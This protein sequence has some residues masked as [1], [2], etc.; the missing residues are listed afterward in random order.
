MAE[1]LSVARKSLLDHRLLELRREQ[2][3]IKVRLF[4]TDHSPA[5]LR[6][7]MELANTSAAG[8]QCACFG[9]VLAGRHPDP[10]THGDHSP[11]AVACAFEPWFSRVLHEHGFHTLCGLPPAPVWVHGNVVGDRFGSAG[12][13]LESDF[14]AAVDGRAP[15]DFFRNYTQVLDADYHFVQFRGLG[16]VPTWLYASRLWTATSVRD[17]ELQKL[18]SLLLFLGKLGED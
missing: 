12:Q 3:A 11:L 6:D 1:H 7:A 4:W 18:A 17:P 10:R 2:E 9:C 8:P 16:A 14:H 15:A 13:V 5:A